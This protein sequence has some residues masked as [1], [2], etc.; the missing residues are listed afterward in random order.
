MINVTYFE[1]QL[2][3][4][5]VQRLQLFMFYCNVMQIDQLTKCLPYQSYIYNTVQ[6]KK[7]HEMYNKQIYI[8]ITFNVGY[9][10]Y[11]CGLL[12]KRV[13]LSLNPYTDRQ[14]KALNLNYAP[15]LCYAA[16]EAKPQA[17]DGSHCRKQQEVS[18]II[19]LYVLCVTLLSLFLPRV[20]FVL[21]FVVC[22]PLF[23]F[24]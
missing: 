2:T 6:H 4:N 19:I 11:V 22:L 23:L 14:V 8:C 7:V 12:V 20:F 18:F 9:N 16:I 10:T 5:E 3:T 1:P 21:G 13:L 24:I 15:F 17:S